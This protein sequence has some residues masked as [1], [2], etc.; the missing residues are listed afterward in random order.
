MIEAHCIT[1]KPHSFVGVIKR[2]G[3]VLAHYEHAL[4]DDGE[5]KVFVSPVDVLAETFMLPIHMY[6]KADKFFA[7][8]QDYDGKYTH[9]ECEFARCTA[10]QE[11]L[12]RWAVDL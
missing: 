9:G 7:S 4:P 11:L 3:E 6:V 10:I 5:V 8:F 2:D 12:I 1:H